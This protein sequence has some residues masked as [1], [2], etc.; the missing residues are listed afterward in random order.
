MSRKEGLKGKKCENEDNE[1]VRMQTL[2]KFS[3]SSIFLVIFVALFVPTNLYIFKSMIYWKWFSVKKIKA[4]ANLKNK[5]GS[6][7]LLEPKA[8]AISYCPEMA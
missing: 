7:S 2:D 8:I 6:F 3:P 1:C 4:L 5:T